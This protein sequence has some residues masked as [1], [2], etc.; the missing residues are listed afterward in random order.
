M[1]VS[2]FLTKEKI[3]KTFFNVSLKQSSRSENL[4]ERVEEGFEIYLTECSA[5]STTEIACGLVVRNTRDM[6]TLGVTPHSSRIID[7]GGN[8]FFG[9]YAQFGN[10]TA[11]GRGHSA[12][13]KMPKN[14]KINGRIKFAADIA[15]NNIVYIELKFTDFVIDFTFLEEAPL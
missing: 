6:R 3:H 8:E 4:G 1:D 13:V 14:V 5:E 9:S 10:D 12:R 11:S 7:S 15:D 2:H